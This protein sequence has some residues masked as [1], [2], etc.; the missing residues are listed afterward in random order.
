[1]SFFAGL[2]LLTACE[3]CD[4]LA[5]GGVVHPF[6]IDAAWRPKCEGK[7][8]VF[9]ERDAWPSAGEMRVDRFTRDCADVSF[10]RAF[11]AADGGFADGELFVAGVIERTFGRSVTT[12]R[13]Q[14]FLGTVDGFS[15]RYQVT[16][17]GDAAKVSASVEG[18]RIT[19]HLV[20]TVLAPASRVVP[21]VQTIA[22]ETWRGRCEIISHRVGSDVALPYFTI[23][24]DRANPEGNLCVVASGAAPVTLSVADDAVVERATPPAGALRSCLGERS[25]EAIAR[26]ARGQ[27]ARYDGG[28][29]AVELETAGLSQAAALARYLLARVV[30]APRAAA[31]PVEARA[32]AL[33][34]AGAIPN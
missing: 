30:P 18:P 23:T 26:L 2:L 9:V 29:S 4:A 25:G 19:S 15:Y 1:M 17:E 3:A 21:R 28:E 7:A 8:S 13:Q 20:S 14:E 33:L 16:G 24:F 5:K 12:I 31:A 22:C 6:A 34:E 10:R 27:T 32:K 11:V